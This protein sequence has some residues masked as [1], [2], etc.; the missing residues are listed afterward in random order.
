MTDNTTELDFGTTAQKATD[1][2]KLPVVLLALDQGRYDMARSLDELR[3]LAESQNRPEDFF[4]CA[5]YRII[6][7]TQDRYGAKTMGKLTGV[8]LAD[9]SGKC[10]S[11]DYTE[12][13][14]P[15]PATISRKFGLSLRC[16]K[17]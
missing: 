13:T 1:A 17:D 8:G 14:G 11:L 10:N 5:G 3:A 2:E 12:T 16:V 15:L 7:G 6:Q 4:C 9:D